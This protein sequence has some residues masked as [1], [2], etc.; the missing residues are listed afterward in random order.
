ME[1]VLKR[2]RSVYK[3]PSERSQFCRST[4]ENISKPSDQ[5]SQ[6]PAVSTVMEQPL[7]LIENRLERKKE[8]ERELH[9]KTELQ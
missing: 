2:R 4:S 1:T 6:E 8:D 7:Q 5:N 9:E 3:N